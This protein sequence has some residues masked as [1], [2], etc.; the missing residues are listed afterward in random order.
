MSLADCRSCLCPKSWVPFTISKNGGTILGNRSWQT[1]RAFGRALSVELLAKELRET[2]GGTWPFCP[3]SSWA[4]DPWLHIPGYTSEPCQHKLGGLA[5]APTTPEITWLHSQAQRLSP[6]WA[7]TC[8]RRGWVSVSPPG[9]QHQVLV[10][11][12]PPPCRAPCTHCH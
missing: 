5:S 6:G 7:L 12:F 1:A 9:A 3:N 4:R 8:S 2:L 11:G 10:S